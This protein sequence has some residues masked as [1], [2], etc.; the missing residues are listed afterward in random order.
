MAPGGSKTLIKGGVTKG[1]VNKGLDAGVG[2][3]ARLLAVRALWAHITVR[4]PLRGW[5]RR[6]LAW[7]ARPGAS[8]CHVPAAPLA[9]PYLAAVVAFGSGSSASGWAQGPVQLTSDPPGLTEPWSSHSSQAS[10]RIAP[11]TPTP[12][13]EPG[14]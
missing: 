5:R 9:P 14:V 8:A 2:R 3:G 12:L 11:C 6:P 10:A 7:V 1:V 13:A 4:L